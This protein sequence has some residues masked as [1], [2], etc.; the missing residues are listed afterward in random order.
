[1]KK[2]HHD[3]GI[4]FRN[5][6]QTWRVYCKGIIRDVLPRKQH[7]CLRLWQTFAERVWLPG[8][9][10]KPT[11]RT[12]LKLHTVW[13]NASMH[14][15]QP[16][17]LCLTTPTAIL[18]K[19]WGVTFVLVHSTGLCTGGTRTRV[20]EACLNVASWAQPP[21]YKPASDTNI[22]GFSLSKMAS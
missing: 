12:W 18:L 9:G 21:R 2:G 5:M 15:K 22:S 8:P 4:V 1:M 20:T 13:T 17:K 19:G 11:R 10:L 3:S 7:N 16:I 14:T 6:L